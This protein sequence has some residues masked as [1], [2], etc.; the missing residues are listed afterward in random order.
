MFGELLLDILLYPVAWLFGYCFLTL[1]FRDPI[2]RKEILK[3]DYENSYASVGTTVASQLLIGIIA[4]VLL[5]LIIGVL[6]GVVY[7]NFFK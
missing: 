5:M 1:K 3:K 7:F 6:I 4:V 2:K